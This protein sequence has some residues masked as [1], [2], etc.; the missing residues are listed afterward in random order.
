MAIVE[1]VKYDGNPDVLVWKYPSQELGTWTQLIVNESQEAVLYKGGKIFDVFQSGRHTLETA[2][3][4]L[5]N[6]VINLPFGGRSPFTAE[7]WFVN[8]LYSLDVKWGTPTPIQIQDPKYGVFVPV[9]AN[10]RFGI[11][12]EDSEKFLIKLVGSVSV[13]DRQSLVKHFRGLYITKAKDTISSYVVHKQVSPLEINAYLDEM[14]I[15][16]KEKMEP[17]M[18]EYGIK[19]TSF[20]VND[21]SI[22]EDDPAVKKLKDALAKKAEMNIIGYSYQ[23]QR[24]FDTLEGVAKNPGT[25]NNP[26]MGVGMGLGMGV[27]MGNAVGKG[28]GD[29]V[30]EIK[31]DDK[32]E[33]KICPKCH[34]EILHG[35]RFCGECG[36]DMTKED[37]K[38]KI[39]C[40]NCGSELNEN[41]KFCMECGKKYNPC[42]NCK[43]DMEDGAQICKVCG[44][45]LLPRCP[46]CG[47]E[48]PKHIKFCPECGESL[49]KHCPKCNHIIDG[50]PKF[51]PECGE[52]LK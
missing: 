43:A 18:S 42:P 21:V 34:A 20:F 39:V 3:I 44:F 50:N 16:L 23:Q 4:P 5:L 8:K 10:G 38:N 6:K 29:M 1:V 33:K 45:E 15:F 48:I 12:I 41:S 52:K 47:A 49:V 17:V 35:Q 37:K 30:E 19:L 36:Y 2:N 25:S 22:P 24:S 46:R 40:A 32:S 14:S 9:R 13:F 27:Q 51:C 28:F 26:L 31:T 7:V 11:Q